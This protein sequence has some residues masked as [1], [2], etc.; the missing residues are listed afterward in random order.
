MPKQKLLRRQKEKARPGPYR[1][2]TWA[3]ELYPD[4]IIVLQMRVSA[5]QLPKT[6]DLSVSITSKVDL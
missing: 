2:H 3:V 6:V 4:F 1:H 5:T